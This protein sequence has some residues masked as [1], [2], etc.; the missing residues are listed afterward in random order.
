MYV[1]EIRTET[2]RLRRPKFETLEAATQ[3][4]ADLFKATG[5]YFG[6]FKEQTKLEKQINK[7]CRQMGEI[8]GVSGHTAEYWKL[9]SKLDALLEKQRSQANETD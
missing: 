4:Q 2:G 6:I 3:L 5:T 7:I 1:M 8:S 9:N